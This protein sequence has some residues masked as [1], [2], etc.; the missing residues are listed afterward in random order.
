MIRLLTSRKVRRK[1]QLQCGNGA[2]SHFDVPQNPVMLT[3]TGHMQWSMDKDQDQAYK[4]QDK[5]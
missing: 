5:D 3:R 1:W 2:V 4:E